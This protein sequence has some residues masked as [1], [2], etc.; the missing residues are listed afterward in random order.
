MYTC[1]FVN[2]CDCSVKFRVVT[3]TSETDVFYTRM[4]S[5]PQI[6][7]RLNILPAKSRAP[8]FPSR[9][10]LQCKKLPGRIP[11]QAVLM[12]GKVL[13]GFF[14]ARSRLVW[15]ESAKV[16][17]AVLSKY[18]HGERIDKT[19]GSLTRI[20]EKIHIEKLVAEHNRPGGQHLG[21][22]E[23]LCVAWVLSLGRVC[24]SHV[25]LRPSCS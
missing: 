5:I 16:R 12:P 23:P 21:L 4:E 19:E 10:K 13:I 15:R 11:C 14:R 22:H 8:V 20:C 2:R 7:I 9:I 6:V 1:P 25:S 17:E 3:V 24:R 18:T